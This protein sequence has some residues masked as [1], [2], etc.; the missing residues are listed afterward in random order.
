[1]IQKAFRE[2]PLKKVSACNN[3]QQATTFTLK[4][5]CQNKQFWIFIKCFIVE[6]I[7]F[8]LVSFF[9][10]LNF[11]ASNDRFVIIQNIKSKFICCWL[12]LIS[13]I[14][15]FL[16]MLY[17]KTISIVILFVNLLC[18]SFVLS[19]AWISANKII[20]ECNNCVNTIHFTFLYLWFWIFF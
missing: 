14:K 20:F 15:M 1:M 8:I 9:A 7:F 4:K 19:F 12:N 10:Y 17:N 18:M 11:Q 3:F 16:N 13:F 6:Y 2:R 5:L